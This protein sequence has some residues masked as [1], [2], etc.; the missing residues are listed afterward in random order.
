MAETPSVGDLVVHTTRN[1]EWGLG[2]I[3]SIADGKMRIRFERGRER[4]FASGGEMI[5]RAD[6]DQV[7]SEMLDRLDGEPKKRKK[8]SVC[9]VALNRSVRS[10]DGRWKSCPRCSV[11]AGEHV[12]RS[13]P[14][15]FGMSG[16]R[17]TEQNPDGIQSYCQECRGGRRV[18]TDGRLCS[19]VR[20]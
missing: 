7:T 9:Q 6:P 5:V 17:T 11:D 8:C 12:F 3:V 1:D 19:V 14:D 13:Y 20:A 10:S 2:R 15:D 4:T 18:T 16:E